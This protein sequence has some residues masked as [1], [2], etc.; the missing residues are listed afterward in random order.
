MLVEI[1]FAIFFP[2]FIFE[3]LGAELIKNENLLLRNIIYYKEHDQ[4]GECRERCILLFSECIARTENLS[5]LLR[6]D[7]EWFI[8]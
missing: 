3:L 8:N 5:Y 4:T 1:M 2:F 6:D 7:C